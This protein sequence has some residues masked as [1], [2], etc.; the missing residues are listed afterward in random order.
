MWKGH[1]G[2]MEAVPVMCQIARW[3]WTLW[4]WKSHFMSWSLSFFFWEVWGNI[5]TLFSVLFWLWEM[6][7]AKQPA[8]ALMYSKMT[9][10]CFLC[11]LNSISPYLYT[12]SLL[13]LF[14]APESWLWDLLRPGS[15]AFCLLVESSQWETQRGYR[16]EGKDGGWCIYFFPSLPD[17]GCFWLCQM[18]PFQG[19]PS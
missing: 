2:P 11:R 7:Y 14:P 3:N 9:V 13:S 12:L 5:H 10:V 1:C 15:F 16:R 6:I 4:I 19:L 17:S 18:I 8:Q